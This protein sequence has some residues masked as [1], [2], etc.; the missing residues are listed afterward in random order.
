MMVARGWAEEG[1][2][3]RWLRGIWVSILWDEKVMEMNGGDGCATLGTGITLLSYTLRKMVKVAK[4]MLCVLYHNLNKKHTCQVLYLHILQYTQTHS[5]S[6]ECV[7]VCVCMCAVVSRLFATP[8]TAARQSSSV[9]GNSPDKNP[10]VGC[11]F[12]LQGIFLTQGLDPHVVSPAL[13]AD[14]LSLSHRGN[15]GRCY[16]A[17][18]CRWENPDKGK[19]WTTWPG[20]KQ[21]DKVQL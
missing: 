1:T 13:Q 12:L 20:H 2:G 16:C 19:L 7:C 5:I 4:F 9:H 11:H 14:S 17:R 21:R 3:S 18:F 8:W 15:P 10:G 6:E